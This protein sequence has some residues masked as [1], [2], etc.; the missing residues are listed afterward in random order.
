MALVPLRVFGAA[1]RTEVGQRTVFVQVEQ[2]THDPDYLRM[3][4]VDEFITDGGWLVIP[5]LLVLLGVSIW[6]VKR[7]LAPIT[8]ISALAESI[9]PMNANIRLPVDQVPVE[10]LPLV[11][12]MNAAL[13][14][15]EQGLQRQ[16]EFNANAAHQLRTP[17]SVLMANVDT[18]KDPEVANRLR[19]DVEHMSRIVSQLLLAAR[20]ETVSINLDEIVDLNDAAAE[21]AG[22]LAPLALA[23]GK[24]IELVRN[25]EPVVIRTNTFAVRAALGNLIE[26]AIKHTPA[27][28]IRTAARHGSSFNRGHGLR[29]GC[30]VRATYE[31]L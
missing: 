12:S 15:L 23:S 7:A 21:I 9:G 20:L 1:L 29:L 28:N 3:A 27:G 13:D 19:T 16:R 10:I 14:H 17:L 30:P 4:V 2:K 11:Q 8:Q 6:I 24:S 5:L 26:N 31:S 25:D 18:L 22:N